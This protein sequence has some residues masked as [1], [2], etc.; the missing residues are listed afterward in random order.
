MVE[1]PVPNSVCEE[2]EEKQNPTVWPSAEDC[3]QRASCDLDDP[4]G[5]LCRSYYLCH[6]QGKDEDHFSQEHC[7]ECGKEISVLRIMPYCGKLKST[8]IYLS[9]MDDS[10]STKTIGAVCQK[11]ERKLWKKGVLSGAGGGQYFRNEH[12]DYDLHL[13]KPF[14]FKHP[15]FYFPD[16]DDDEEFW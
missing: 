13:N 5:I 3:A 7:L 10:F 9:R 15:E 1:N 6:P 2:F 4:S 16:E 12:P 14:K 11:C 8:G